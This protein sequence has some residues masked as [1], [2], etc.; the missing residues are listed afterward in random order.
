MKLFSPLLSL[1][2]IA[3]CHSVDEKTIQQQIKINFISRLEK[4][5][6]AVILDS[7]SIVKIDT[8]SAKLGRIIEDSVYRQEYHR[9]GVQFDRASK[10]QKKDSMNFYQDELNY[11][12]KQ[13]EPLEKSIPLSDSTKGYGFL[14]SC[15]YQ[16]RI[17]DKTRKD[18]VFYFFDKDMNIV[19]PD[20]L[21][22]WIQGG[23]R[24]LKK[25]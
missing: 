19:R 6:S 17:N 1:L 13:I 10:D 3:S 15:V 2:V 20:M 5:D 9:V 7:F 16:I 11:M 18:R 25:K 8:I 12:A 23:V 22:M 24:R 21:D 4:A 14:I